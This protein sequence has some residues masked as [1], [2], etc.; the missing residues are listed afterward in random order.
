MKSLL[1][2]P[3]AVI[4]FAVSTASANIVFDLRATSVDAA[5][6]SLFEAKGVYIIPGNPGGNITLE[7]WAQITNPNA[8]PGNPIG[9]F[10]VL[11]SVVSYTTGPGVTGAVGPGIFE[12]PFS[13]GTTAGAAAEVSQAYGGVPDNIMDRGS[14]STTAVTN[15]VKSRSDPADASGT[16]I[17]AQY[18]VTNQTPRGAQINPITNGFEFLMGR[19]T[20]SIS[21]FGPTSSAT[22]NWAIPPFS[23]VVNRGQIANWVDGSVAAG[24]AA[25]SKNGN[26]TSELGLGSPILIGLIPE[27]SA[28]SMLILGAMGL[29]GFRRRGLRR[30]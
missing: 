11:G 9:L 30:G 6:G 29:V 10:T 13:I 16:Q 17:G 3:A 21:A 20:L 22:V 24:P 2:L 14:L 18:F 4:V 8:V 1:V 23:S 5:L 28:F 12:A 26:L 25:V 15:Y 27:P 7:L 19:F